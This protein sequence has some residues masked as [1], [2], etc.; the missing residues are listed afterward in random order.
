MATEDGEEVWESTAD[1]LR[2][3]RVVEPM[4]RA[5]ALVRVTFANE[6]D[7]PIAVRVIEEVP[8]DVRATTLVTAVGGDPDAWR[9]S[10][11]WIVHEAVLPAASERVTAYV[12][13]SDGGVSTSLPPPRV[14]VVEPVAGIDDERADFAQRQA[15]FE[16]RLDAI[17]STLS[18]LTS[19]IASLREGRRD[20]RQVR[21]RE[22]RRADRRMDDLADAL[23]DLRGDVDEFESFRDRFRTAFSSG[24]TPAAPEDESD[25]SDA[26]EEDAAER[27]TPEEDVHDRDTSEEDVPDRNSSDEVAAEQG[28]PEASCSRE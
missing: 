9:C 23:A 26:P 17:E 18:D 24:S 1:E 7:G 4:G 22:R 15:R 28:A 2:L 6:S 14:R 3:R 5:G 21:A 12:L 13:T 16:E 8:G 27:D 19:E 11:E 25:D 20:D 10:E